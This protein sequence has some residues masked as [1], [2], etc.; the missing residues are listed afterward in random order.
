MLL[1][2]QPHTGWH[3]HESHSHV[4]IYLFFFRETYQFLL[5]F[6]FRAAV[7]ARPRTESSLRGTD[8]HFFLPLQLDEVFPVNVSL[9]Y[10]S[11]VNFYFIENGISNLFL[12]DKKKKSS[13]KP[14]SHW[15]SSWLEVTQS[16]NEDPPDLL[17]LCNSSQ[18]AAEEQPPLFWEARRRSKNIINTHIFNCACDEFHAL[19]NVHFRLFHL[20]D[21]ICLSLPISELA[22]RHF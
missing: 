15:F 21:V 10:R 8:R 2:L 6:P 12:D 20:K 5:A 7:A 4:R 17:C 11:N 18:E 16:N 14:C 1:F 9:R 22:I 19:C 3:L 13:F